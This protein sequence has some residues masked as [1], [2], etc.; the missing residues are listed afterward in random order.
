MNPSL[1]RN[2]IDRFRDIVAQRYGL[3]FDDSKRDFLADVLQKQVGRTGHEDVSSFLQ[4]LA[5][6]HLVGTETVT[7]TEELTVGE[8]YFFRHPDQ[9][10]AFTEVALL[11]RL[12][13]SSTKF[14]LRILSAG[15][16][17]GEEAYSLAILVR[18]HI[19]AALSSDSR[20]VGIDLNA[21]SLAKAQQAKYSAWSL[22][23]MPDDFRQ[24]YFR[25]EKVFALDESA[26]SLVAFEERNLNDEADS[27]WQPDQFDVI[28]CRNVVMYFTPEAARG[29]IARL[30]RSLVPGG[31]LF[32]GPAETL[33]GVSQDYHLRHTHDTF[34]YQRRTP[35]ETPQV[36]DF[37]SHRVLQSPLTDLPVLAAED[38]SWV[39][40]I[41]QASERIA[42]LSREMPSNAPASNA[43]PR[44]ITNPTPNGIRPDLQAAREMVRQERYM[45]ALAMLRSATGDVGQDPDTR[46]L[47]AVI[48]TNSGQ[49]AEAEQLCQQVLAGDELN[50]EAHYLIALCREH[51]KEFEAATEHDH[52]AIYLDSQ[53]AMPHLHLGLLSK[54]VGDQDGIR[55]AFRAA[56]MLLPREDTG[57]ILLFGGGFSREMLINLC[58]AELRVCGGEA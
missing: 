49:V 26:R 25:G 32:L 24:R 50:A 52:T 9:F 33:R 46:L 41:S 10:R 47:L 15:C 40:A 23:G 34:Y 54:R 58:D 2:T 44:A 19:P 8:T 12:R 13:A 28:F 6:N 51:A 42:R 14:R 56:Q 35:E 57:R 38:A 4:R 39:S 22:R 43:P 45:D 55:R 53:F 30:T 7:L 48:L 5:T 17:S 16:A 27:F 18:Q 3:H 31:F 21:T 11:A 29:V 36:P 1:D 37:S 20:I